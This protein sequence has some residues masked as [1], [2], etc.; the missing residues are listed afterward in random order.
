MKR[1]SFSEEKLEIT[2]VII[3]S[4]DF[5]LT[6]KYLVKNLGLKVKLMT[7]EE[8][9][10]RKLYLHAAS[11]EQVYA[12]NICLTN[13]RV[14]AINYPVLLGVVANNE[15]AFRSSFKRE[16]GAIKLS[17]I[18]RTHDIL[19]WRNGRGYQYYSPEIPLCL[20]SPNEFNLGQ[21]ARCYDE[22]AVL[23]WLQISENVQYEDDSIKGNS[24][25]H[26]LTI[27]CRSMERSIEYYSMFGIG[28]ADVSDDF[29]EET[30]Q[31]MTDT[32]IGIHLV[33]SLKSDPNDSNVIF[34]VV[35]EKEIIAI[36]KG[37]A[38]NLFA[39]SN[40]GNPDYTFSDSD[41]LLTD[42]NR[43]TWDINSSN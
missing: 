4:T 41:E 38:G 37:C 27:E 36:P 31:L 11:D 16:N 17:R 8:T 9:G 3:N 43:C 19:R 35:S 7:I 34:S 13:D 14:A 26:W 20:L 42:I 39:S 33:N 12:L 25:M 21:F 29:D 2:T 10:G 1:K 40:Q 23:D 22:I 32:N 24:W 6:A 5:L 28:I 15:E 30:Y 18:G